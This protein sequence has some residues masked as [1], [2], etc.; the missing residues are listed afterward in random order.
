MILPSRI[1][2]HAI[3]GAS[4][5]ILALCADAGLL[6]EAGRYNEA[7]DI[8]RDW[9]I[10][11][12]ERPITEGLSDHAKAVLLLRVGY[13]SGHVGSA[14]QIHDA[15]GFAQALICES[16]LLFEGVGDNEG[17]AEALMHLATCYWR[18]GI[19]S[20]A[21]AKVREALHK[22]GE[23]RGEKRYL[24]LILLATILIF[25]QRAPEGLRV[26]TEESIGFSESISTSTRGKYRNALALALKKVGQIE[27][28]DTYFERAIVEFQDAGYYFEMAGNVSYLA[29]VE[30]N[31]GSLLS[32][33]QEYTKAHEHLDR[34][35]KLYLSPA[36]RDISHAAQVDDTRANLFMTEGR[37]I[38][39]EEAAR[40]SITALEKSEEKAALL[41]SLFTYGRIL[42]QLER[43]DDALPIFS[44]ARNIAVQV[45]DAEREKEAIR[46][47][48]ED[49]LG[50]VCVDA[51]IPCKTVLRIMERG[52][53]RR[54][55]DLSD[56]EVTQASRLLGYKT[57]QTL[58]SGIKDRHPDL[59][60]A[61]STVFKRK[62]YGPR[63]RKGL[64]LVPQQTE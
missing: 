35:R 48:I 46:A 20:E 16:Q 41:E 64:S 58:A 24:A 1:R 34:A 49:C 14:Q 4:N 44:R 56:K 17:A 29:M 60:F 18:E 28:D 55:L 37:L 62:N 25:A 32:A 15:A 47:T 57:H 45:G 43:Y 21:E 8:L 54:A 52:L 51:G 22:F 13:L 10:R 50:P 9:W 59:Q 53:Y 27:Q 12:G 7:R 33:K 30:N 26:L 2:R 3:E 63:K 23:D 38:E 6:A 40:A 11:I 61:R 39:A 31:L 5:E 42:C 36:L 19:Y